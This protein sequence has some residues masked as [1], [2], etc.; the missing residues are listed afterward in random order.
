[1][2]E[3][4]R[5]VF[6]YKTNDIE[7]NLP[8][9]TLD[10]ITF[11]FNR[12]KKIYKL[13]HKEYNINGYICNIKRINFV[14]VFFIKLQK[15]EI[16]ISYFH[17]N[18]RININNES[19]KIFGDDFFTEYGILNKE[20]FISLVDKIYIVVDG[21]Y[22]EYRHILDSKYDYKYY[23]ASAINSRNEAKKEIIKFINN[24]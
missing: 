4:L 15:V 9:E 16:G 5:K 17:G 7:S 22:N 13:E 3:R 24:V 23:E 14:S 12:T 6:G 10:K 8:K 1:M 19:Y 20:E 11:I 21:F 2:L 18:I